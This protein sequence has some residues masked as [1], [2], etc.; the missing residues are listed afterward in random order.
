MLLD[1]TRWLYTFA[2]RVFKGVSK[3]RRAGILS[4]CSQPNVPR[5]DHLVL[6]ANADLV[7]LAGRGLMLEYHEVYQTGT[8]FAYFMHLGVVGWAGDRE[9][10]GQQNGR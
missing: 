5:R 4:E 9:W 6:A 7:R 2:E 3:L 1:L 10:A 8:V